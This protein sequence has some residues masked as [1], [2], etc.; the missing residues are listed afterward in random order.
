MRDA[1]LLPLK[2]VKNRYYVFL[3][4]VARIWA[5]FWISH[6]GKRRIKIK[7]GDSYTYIPFDGDRYRG[8]IIN[9]KIQVNND[10]E[11]TEKEQLE[12]L[13][14]LFDKGIISKDELLERIPAGMVANV[15]SINR[16]VL[17]NDGL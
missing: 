6:Y 3:E 15:N 1:A 9:T 12:T 2:I 7:K 11:Y 10:T 13:L 17:K 8:L 4:D 16:E 5:D 14:T